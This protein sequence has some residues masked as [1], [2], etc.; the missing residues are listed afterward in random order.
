[1]DQD[2]SEKLAKKFLIE[3]EL[4]KKI[5]KNIRKKDFKNIKDSLISELV[6]EYYE[7]SK[8]IGYSIQLNALLG[9]YCI[10][11]ISQKFWKKYNDKF[12]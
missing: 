3:S 8:Q 10:L 11:N 2:F 5:S 9:P 4:V 7:F 6:E 1:M 12:A